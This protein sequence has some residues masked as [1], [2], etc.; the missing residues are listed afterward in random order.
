MYTQKYTLISHSQ[1]VEK[2]WERSLKK[3]IERDEIEK[4]EWVDSIICISWEHNFKQWW[5]IDDKIE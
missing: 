4:E 1:L 3:G 5:K 2:V